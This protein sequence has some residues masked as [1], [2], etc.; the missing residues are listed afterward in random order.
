MLMGNGAVFI[1]ISTDEDEEE[2]EEEEGGGIGGEGEGLPGRSSRLG[3]N[4]WSKQQCLLSKDE[5][6]KL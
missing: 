4:T 6:I 5:D 2:E 1:F 3:K